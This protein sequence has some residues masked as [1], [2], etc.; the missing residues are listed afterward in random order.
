MNLLIIGHA[1]HGKDTVAEML[2]K[3]YGFTFES[4]SEAA[5][6]I[7]LYD[8]LKNKYGYT[9]PV[10]CFIDRVNHRAEW[11]QLICEYNT[12]DKARLAKDILSANDIYVGMRDDEELWECKKQKLFDLIIGVYN[13]RKPEEDKSSF[14]INLWEQSDIIIPNSTTIEDLRKR[15]LKLD[16]LF[17]GN[18][19][20][21]YLD[22]S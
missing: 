3:L 12:P 15:V 4:S 6:R 13:H 22:N 1:R 7:F 5:S 16:L 8:K 18:Y 17:N 11:H 2:N 20:E 21:Q 14:N 19:Y 9:G 10:E